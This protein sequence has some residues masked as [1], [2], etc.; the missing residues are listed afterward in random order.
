MIDSK[1]SLKNS[2]IYFHHLY[3]NIYKR[4]DKTKLKAKNGRVVH[5]MLHVTEFSQ[6]YAKSSIIGCIS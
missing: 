2:I 4:K 1:K 3:I 5:V 6:T